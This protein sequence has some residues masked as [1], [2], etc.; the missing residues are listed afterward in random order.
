MKLQWTKKL[1]NSELYSK[2]G[3][4]F[5]IFFTSD[6]L[7]FS[8]VKY[9]KNLGLWRNRFHYRYVNSYRSPYR[10][11]WLSIPFDITYLPKVVINL[12]IDVFSSDHRVLEKP[13]LFF[14]N[15]ELFIELQPWYMFFQLL[16]T[17]R[18]Y[19]NLGLSRHKI[20]E[21]Y[22]HKVPQRINFYEA[23][24]RLATDFDS[25]SLK[26]N[27]RTFGKVFSREKN[28]WILLGDSQCQKMRN[29]LL[30]GVC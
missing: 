21:L 11:S 28:R 14:T 24:K 22:P 23:L 3:T 29:I 17:S 6:F 13:F 7:R 25:E 4:Y 15:G 1:A 2:L 5:Q 8:F 16:K 30:Y 19:F 12:I 18:F 20:S 26:I 9:C 27:S 10:S